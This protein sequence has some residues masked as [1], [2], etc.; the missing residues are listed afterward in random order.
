MKIEQ[1]TWDRHVG[2]S[3]SAA[4]G[5]MKADLVL[6]FGSVS[7]FERAEP[8]A[9][10]KAFYPAARFAGCSTAGEIR[11][12]QVL[13]ETLVA[14]ALQFDRAAVRTA[15]VTIDEMSESF[16]AGERLA[17]LL[18][19]TAE[20]PAP[21]GGEG[22]LVHVFVFSDGLH[23]NGSDLVRGLMQRLPARVTATG[24]L[25]ADGARFSATV[26][27]ADG[28][29]AAKTVAAVA[30]Y[31]SALRVGFGSLGGWDPFGPERMI[32]RSRGN[33]LCELDGR[34]ALELYEQYLGD[35]ARE[36]PASGLLYPL[37]LRTKSGEPAVVRTIL[38]VDRER[39]TMTFAGDMPEGS[40]ARLMKANFDRLIDGAMGAAQTSFEAIGERDP[41]FALLISCVGRKLVLKQ[42]VE[43]EVEGVRDVLGPRTVLAGFY[44]YGE[45]SPFTPGAKCELHNQTM[46]VT[47]LS[48][49][50]T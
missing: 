11:G 34:S 7:A 36:L 24:G 6:V 41:D 31:G 22:P 29:P 45:I 32:T 3:A 50:E 40:Y 35:Q 12:T 2:W 16:S 49:M 19:P 38:A 48:E 20:L 46:T 17:Q 33:V 42:R 1:R 39:M 9:E 28:G 14:T 37:S 30:L 47:T 15:S 23:V 10:L 8:L 18:P 27:V 44:S 13:D 5:E 26:V 43:E 25:A 21:A 4:A